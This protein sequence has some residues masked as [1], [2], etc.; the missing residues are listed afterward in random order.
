MPAHWLLAR[1]GKKVMRPGGSTLSDVLL[2]GLAIGPA[3]D[4]V[5][6][7]GEWGRI[8]E[9]SLTY[10]V[11][12]VWD[13]RRLVLPINYFIEKPFQNWTR[14]NAEVLGAVFLRVDY[15]APIPELRAELAR[16]AEAS[17][18]WDGRSVGLQVTDSRDH[19]LELRAL[20]SAADG[21]RA[22]DLRCEVREK[23][24]AFLR[25]NYPESLPRIRTTSGER[26]E[27]VYASAG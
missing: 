3:D 4:V 21:S 16:I 26:L 13:Q 5:V 9:I 12:R 23:L 6:V 25:D 27:G 20:V 11:V 22:W 18:Y 2:S 15:T 19:T 1:L 8:E 7:E 10:V 17:P 24:I 14:N